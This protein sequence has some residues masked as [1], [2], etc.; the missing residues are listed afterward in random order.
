M[1][2][3]FMD[4]VPPAS[5]VMEVKGVL[6]TGEE[7]KRDIEVKLQTM[8]S[9]NGTSLHSLAAVRRLRQLGKVYFLLLSS[10]SPP[11]LSLP[12]IVVIG[13]EQRF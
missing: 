8:H 4:Q 2:Y 11:F 1:L 7:Y 5:L 13:P 9:F 12:I 3:F 10:L 6:N